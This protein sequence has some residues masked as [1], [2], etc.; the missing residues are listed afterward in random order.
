[1]KPFYD[2]SSKNVGYSR[3]GR[4]LFHEN[5]KSYIDTPHLVLPLKSILMKHLS[6]LEE[7][8]DHPIF[9]ITREIYLKISFLQ[10]KFRNT[11]FIYTHY[12]SLEEFLETLDKSLTIFSQSNVI[13]LIPFNIPTTAISRDFAREQV[14][15]HLSDIKK[16]LKNHPELRFGLTIKVFDY[17]ELIDSYIRLVKNHPNIVLLN[18]SDLFDNLSNFRN[19]IRTIIKIK[20]ELD[21]NI[22]LMASGKIIPSFYPL[23]VYIGFDL[24]N[25]SYLLYLSSENYYNTTENLLPLYKMKFLPCSCPAC[26]ENLI[27]LLQ[28]KRSSEKTEL[29]T[30][31]NL[32]SAKNYMLKIK[33]YISTEDFRGF[34][35]NSIFANTNYISILRILDTQYFDKIRQETPITQDKK[36]IICLGPSSYHRPDFEEFRRRAV[37]E[38]FPEPWTKMILILPCS[39]RKP[40]SSSKSH[41]AFHSVI[42]KFPEFPS[43]QEFILTSP[44]G[45]IPRQ[46]EEIYPINAYD[47][48]VTGD[49]DNEEITIA[50]DMLTRMI[51]KYDE[52]IPIVCHVNDKGYLECLEKS[53][54]YLKRTFFYSNPDDKLT[55]KQ[56]L[57]SLE[58]TIRKNK[59][60]Y[61]PIENEKKSFLSSSIFRNCVKIL[62]YQFGSGSGMLLFQN[63]I[64]VKKNRPQTRLII[65]DQKTNENLGEFIYKTGQIELSMK[66]ARRLLPHLKNSNRILYDGINIR[67][68]TLFRPGIFDYSDDLI[69]NA[70]VFILDNNAEKLLALGQMLVGSN[71]IKNSKTG[72]I[73]KIYAKSN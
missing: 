37:L 47:I 13:P 60:I 67:G 46:L 56:S 43:F 21:N 53:S 51:E 50:A 17:P 3:V 19:I 72:K 27:K 57:N 28:Q 62:D 54:N 63:G 44:L 14:T 20:E 6:F 34:V 24:I 69:P 59:D 52:R 33:Q 55:S 11:N 7:L 48:S 36:D 61:E 41:K 29:L 12:G 49:W 64:K 15:F 70:Y 22:L 8:Q 26:R 73:A 40:Y 9:L 16:I 35:E 68:N 58:N 65:K 1:M 42:R 32:F 39:A 25:G 2:L 45:A 10:E 30:L 18:I 38:F 71:Y 31:H 5:S 23:L 4:A 66:G